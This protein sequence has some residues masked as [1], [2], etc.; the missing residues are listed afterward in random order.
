VAKTNSAFKF[1]KMNKIK[2]A[3]IDNPEARNVFRR[4]MVDA[5][6]SYMASKNRKF[7]DPSTAQKSNR[8]TSNS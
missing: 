5:Q 8:P 3:N 7:S 1:G 6:A 2:L 4:A